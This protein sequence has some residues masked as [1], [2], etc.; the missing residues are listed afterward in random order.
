MPNSDDTYGT[1]NKQTIM[2]TQNDDGSTALTTFANVAAAQAYI[3]STEALAVYNECATTIQ[4][5]L[6]ADGDGNNTGLKVTI[7]FGTKGAGTDAADD[8]A[9]QF[10]ARRTALQDADPSNWIIIQDQIWKPSFTCT[11]ISSH[12]F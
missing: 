7:D 2:H 10:N 11:S 12:L 3:Y 4:W 8:W 1:Y 6:V 9:G 5:A